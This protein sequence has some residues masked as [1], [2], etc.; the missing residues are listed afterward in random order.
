MLFTSIIGALETTVGAIA[1]GVNLLGR[2]PEQRARLV[3]DPSLMP[4]AVEEVLRIEPSA[5]A[6]ARTVLVE[7]E[8]AGIHLRPGERVQVLFRRSES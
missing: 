4:L 8:V 3:A 5:G 7:T 6:A 1:L 2:H